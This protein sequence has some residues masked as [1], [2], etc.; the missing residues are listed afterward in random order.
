MTAQIA[1]WVLLASCLAMAAATA[2]CQTSGRPDAQVI[3]CSDGVTIKGREPVNRYDDHTWLGIGF[4]GQ[5]SADPVKDVQVTDPA[6][7]IDL[8]VVRDVPSGPYVTIAEGTLEIAGETC[9]LNVKRL[10]S[11]LAPPAHLGV[12]EAQVRSVEDGQKEVIVLMV[13][14]GPA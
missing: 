7:S 3:R 5:P 8:A 10:K 12:P 6:S 4:V 13:G 11:G 2:A 1:R 14:P 9:S